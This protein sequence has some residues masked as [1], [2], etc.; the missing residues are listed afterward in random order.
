MVG[1]WGI[2]LG[3]HSAPDS[4]TADRR[5]REHDTMRLRRM[6][7]LDIISKTMRRNPCGKSQIFSDEVNISVIIRTQDKH[8]VDGVGVWKIINDYL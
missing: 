2:G 3:I 1:V 6:A 5:L 4:D 7:R 8:R